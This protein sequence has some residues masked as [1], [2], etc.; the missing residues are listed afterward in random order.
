VAFLSI[1]IVYLFSFLVFREAFPFS[2]WMLKIRAN[3]EVLVQESYGRSR[4]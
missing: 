1:A 4:K 2:G 3:K